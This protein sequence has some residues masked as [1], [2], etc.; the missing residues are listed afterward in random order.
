MV[1]ELNFAYTDVYTGKAQTGE[2]NAQ[3]SLNEVYS[4]LSTEMKSHIYTLDG[5]STISLV[6]SSQSSITLLNDAEAIGSTGTAGQNTVT[7]EINEERESTSY[8]LESDGIYYPMCIRNFKVELDEENASTTQPTGAG[9]LGSGIEISFIDD[10]ET[11]EKSESN[12]ITASRDET[13]ITIT[14]TENTG[15]TQIVL[16]D[17]DVTLTGNIEVTVN[18]TYTISLGTMTNGSVS[19]TT[20]NIDTTSNTKYGKDVDIMLTARGNKKYEFEKWY[21]EDTTNPKEIKINETTSGVIYT[22]TFKEK[23]KP[24][25]AQVQLN[26]GNAITVKGSNTIDDNW[27]LFYVDDDDNDESTAEYVHLIYG[28]YYPANVQTEI[29]SG[30]TIFAPAHRD[31]KNNASS[32]SSY[33]WSVN[34]RK[35]RLTLLKYLKNNSS[36]AESNLDTSTPAGSYESWTNLATAL[37]TG[38]GKALNG[39]TIRV[40]GAPNITMWVDSWNEQGYRELALVSTGNSVIGYS[41]RLATSEKS[42]YS[43]GLIGDIGYNDELYFP[44][45]NCNAGN[46]NADKAN[47]YWLASPGG[48]W[49]YSLCCVGFGGDISMNGSPYYIGSYMYTSD[50]VRPVVS[51]LKSDFESIEAFSKISIEK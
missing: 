22:A 1:E 46:K 42:G 16:R 47:A 43:I 3:I 50:S 30:N 45:K 7:V 19:I 18:P 5:T 26:G 37:T 6:D 32:D 31:D 35:N 40:Q 2:I 28:D 44:Y 13:T 4:K 9:S 23:P 39:K 20:N 38:T 17:G 41:I 11:E 10:G 49:D 29:T 14:A 33:A 24:Y 34:S 48:S 15:T 21:D 12:F 8:Y 36:Y 27:K 51:I 25:G